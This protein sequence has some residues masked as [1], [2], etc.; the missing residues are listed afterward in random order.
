MVLIKILYPLLGFYVCLSVLVHI[1]ALKVN[2]GL[3]YT[4]W[5]V[6]FHCFGI[7]VFHIVNI[8]YV[9]FEVLISMVMWRSAFWDPWHYTP[10][11]R[12]P[13]KHDRDLYL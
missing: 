1:S 11:D 10:E 3:K 13:H 2:I 7:P 9:G 6:V 4:L 5:I 8:M 12:T